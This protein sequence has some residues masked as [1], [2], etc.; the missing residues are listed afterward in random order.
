MPNR[1]IKKIL[2]AN[3]YDV[4]KETPVDRAKGLS[5]RL[6]NNV[7]IK[8]EDLQPVFSFKL[9]GAYNCLKHLSAAEQ[10]AGVVAASA[11]NHAQGLAMSAQ[12]LGVKA[13]IVMP[14]TTPEIKVNSVRSFGA[15]VILH[16]DGFADAYAYSLQLVQD[17]GYVY[18]HPF[19]NDDVIAGQ[20]TVAVELMRQ[21]AHI[22]AVF[23][24]VGGG[25]LIAGM[26]VYL[27]YLNPSIRVIG[28]EPEDSCCLQAAMQAGERVILEEVGIFADGVAVAQIGERPFA[29]AQ[30]YVDEVVT[31][32]TDELCAAIKDL[33]DDT[34]AITEPAGACSVAGLKKYV[35]REGV[36]GQHLVAIASGANINFD[37]LRH[38]AERAEIG[39]R[40]EA[41]IAA[42]IAER[43]GSFKRFCQ[44]LGERNVTEFNYRYA[45]AENA[46]VFV[47]VQLNADA[48]GKNELLAELAAADIQAQDLSDNEMAKI[49][50]RY[51]VGGHAQVENEVVYRFTFPERPGA[52]M[53]FLTK[54]GQNWN[55][56]MFHYRNHGSAY[57]RVLVGLQVPE[58]D[59]A[60]LV[61]YLQELGYAFHEET[62][63]PAYQLFLS[64]S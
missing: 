31:V 38:V 17:K 6:H 25:G 27:K 43:P 46:R 35:D 53:K 36:Q 10:A 15:K 47:G 7:F 61:G 9:R 29:L 12:Y 41:I 55:I 19:D 5:A 23:V 51:M 45:D 3:V 14:T 39:E 50:I 24:P 64:P 20:G 63:N 57:G 44:A 54:L 62:E 13:T 28:V 42:S 56:S 58:T 8:R 60:R 30:K 22:D 4:A 37:R 49:H 18:I 16:G 40:R 11:G 1:Y 21:L 2:S 59:K 32:T 26:A 48:G 33:Y 52:L 34:R